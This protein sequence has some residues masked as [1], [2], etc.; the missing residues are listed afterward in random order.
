MEEKRER[1]RRDKER[2]KA[3]ARRVYGRIRSTSL[4]WSQEEQDEW[5]Q[6]QGRLADHIKACS[7]EACGNPR[8]SKWNKSERL[9]LQ[10]RR[11]LEDDGE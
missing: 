11:F 2:M 8:R 5:I 4:G 10:E 1:R 9:T 7:C 6:R 3:R